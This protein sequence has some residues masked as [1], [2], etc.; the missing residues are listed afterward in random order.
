MS[1]RPLTEAEIELALSDLSGWA[2]EGDRLTRTWTFDGHLA[3]LAAA[4]AVGWVQERRN[5][6]AD[7]TIRYN[8]LTV[9]TTTHSAGNKV[10]AKDTELAGAVSSLL[11]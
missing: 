1:D 5:H 10:S 2:H 8:R 9:S 7:L 11:D 6:H 4:G 3:A